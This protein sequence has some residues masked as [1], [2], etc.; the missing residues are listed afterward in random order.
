M[1]IF[2]S[3]WF[4]DLRL[5]P[6]KIKY[7][8]IVRLEA[9]SS[10]QAK[11]LYKKLSKLHFRKII[12]GKNLPK[13]S[14]FSNPSVKG[15]LTRNGSLSDEQISSICEKAN[16]PSNEKL[17]NLSEG[18]RNTVD[19]VGLSGVN[20]FVL[21]STVGMYISCLEVCYEVIK[22]ILDKGGACIEVTYPPFSGENLDKIINPE[23]VD[24]GISGDYL[25]KSMGSRLKVI[26]V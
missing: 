9:A 12:V 11:S 10:I 24:V 20:E 26:R 6:I 25:S 5:P 17:F 19:L 8:E 13:R 15:Y 4:K 7:G 23:L 22:G 14:V 16:I 21:L 3:T 1:Y 2:D 18:Q